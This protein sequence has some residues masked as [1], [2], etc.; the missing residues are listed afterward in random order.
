MKGSQASALVAAATRGM[1]SRK[2]SMSSPSRTPKTARRI[3]SRVMACMR[4]RSAKVRPTG[5][6]ATSRAVASA[7]SSA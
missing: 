2:R 6:R 7:I 5:Q 3:T 1:A 4:G